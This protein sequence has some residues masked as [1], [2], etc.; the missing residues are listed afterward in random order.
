MDPPDASIIPVGD[1]LGATVVL[2]TCMYKDVEFLHVGYYL[3]NEYIEPEMNENPPAKPDISKIRRTIADKEA[4]V[5][6]FPHRFD[7]PAGEFDTFPHPELLPGISKDAAD[8]DAGH[9]YPTEVG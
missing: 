5:T 6:K 8:E 2:L 7:F 1:I 3:N 9:G 4:R